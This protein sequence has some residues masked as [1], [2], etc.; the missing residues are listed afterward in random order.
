[1]TKTRVQLFSLLALP[2]LILSVIGFARYT[3]TAQEAVKSAAVTSEPLL[4]EIAGYRQWT[5]VNE[6]PQLVIDPSLVGG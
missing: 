6:R 3:T 2:L 4:T 5:R 1:M